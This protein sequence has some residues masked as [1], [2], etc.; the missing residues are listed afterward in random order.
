MCKQ[1]RVCMEKSSFIQ[2]NPP[3]GGS[4]KKQLKND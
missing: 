2:K 4:S 1:A 3:E